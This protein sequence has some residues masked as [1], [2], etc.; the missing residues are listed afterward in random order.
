MKGA[1]IYNAAIAAVDGNSAEK[2]GDEKLKVHT[3]SYCCLDYAQVC[4]FVFLL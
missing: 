4:F 1:K 2:E 3:N